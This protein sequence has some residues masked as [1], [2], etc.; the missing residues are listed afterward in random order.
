MPKKDLVRDPKEIPFLLCFISA[1]PFSS[2]GQ[3]Q[4]NY[5][6]TLFS[7]VPSCQRAKAVNMMQQIL[8]NKAPD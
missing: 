1:F 6:F 4:T 5:T 8:A 7:C 3:L 2:S